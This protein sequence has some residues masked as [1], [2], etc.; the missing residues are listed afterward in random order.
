[1]GYIEK[2]GITFY[3]R[4]FN[5]YVRKMASPNTDFNLAFIAQFEEPDVL[6]EIINNLQLAIMGNFDGVTNTDMSCN[7][8]L[9]YITPDSVEFYEVDF[10]NADFDKR[11]GPL[12]V[13]TVPLQDIYDLA[14]AWRDFLLE[15]PLNWSIVRSS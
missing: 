1:M 4:I 8:S 13:G 2:H 11:G 6:T 15:P 9:A 5:G 7:E 12:F 10:Y 3:N 14:V